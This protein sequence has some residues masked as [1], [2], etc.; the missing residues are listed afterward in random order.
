MLNT[1][2]GELVQ[3]EQDAKAECC[4]QV[5]GPQ[6]LPA[7]ARPPGIEWGPDSL[8]GRHLPGVG[9]QSGPGEELGP[10]G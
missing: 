7:G 5:A 10:F 4:G 3:T 2:T 8:G 6:R 9:V 1:R